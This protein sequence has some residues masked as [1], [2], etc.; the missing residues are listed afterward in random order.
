MA[1]SGATPA[2]SALRRIFVSEVLM[3]SVQLLRRHV[4]VC[5][6][7]HVRS[8]TLMSVCLSLLSVLWFASCSLAD[9]MTL[10]MFWFCPSSRHSCLLSLPRTAPVRLSPLSS[11]PPS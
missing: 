2:A 9:F 8:V 3:L 4:A 7:P 11:P 6:P 1:A 10:I 5:S